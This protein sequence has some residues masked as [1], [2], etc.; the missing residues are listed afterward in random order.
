[1]DLKGILICT[2][3]WPVASLALGIA[4]LAPFKASATQTC[5][6]FDIPATTP[7]SRFIINTDGTVTDKQTNLIWKRCSE[8]LEGIGCDRGNTVTYTWQE[9]ST[10]AGASRFAGKSDWRIPSIGELETLIEYQCTMPAINTVIFPATPVRNFWS[11][12]P[13]AG[14]VNGSWNINF[15]DG[16]KDSCSRNYRLHVR[17][18]RGSVSQGSQK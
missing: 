4:L 15:N 1:M 6:P 9:A 10:V 12:S 17:L 7:S 18:V 3:R 16:V 14:Y 13:Y 5:R 2:Y 8:G 11:A